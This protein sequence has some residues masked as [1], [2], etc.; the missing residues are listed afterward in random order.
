MAS[1]RTGSV[2]LNGSLF[3][4]LLKIKTLKT[5]LLF[6]ISIYLVGLCCSCK[7]EKVAQRRQVVLHGD[8]KFDVKEDW[9]NCT[10]DTATLYQYRFVKQRKKLQYGY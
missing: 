9:T 4:K 1:N 5:I 3:K 8:G 10:F 6:I 7:T 2:I